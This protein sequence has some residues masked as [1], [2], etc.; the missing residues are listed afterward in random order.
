MLSTKEPALMWAWVCPITGMVL[1]EGMGNTEPF[2]THESERIWGKKRMAAGEM[3]L[4]RVTV[5]PLSAEETGKHRAEFAEWQ[6]TKR[7]KELTHNVK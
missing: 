3:L 5:E 2:A 4:C 7:A 1:H 6:Q